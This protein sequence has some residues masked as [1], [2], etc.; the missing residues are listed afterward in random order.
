MRQVI[1]DTETTGLNPATG[2]RII[3]IGCVEMVGR[4]LTDRTSITTLILSAISMLA[5]LLFTDS[6]V[7]SYLTSQY[8]Q[9]LLRS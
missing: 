2:D 9:V 3:E 8:L 7:S 4:R 6:L 1:L 5:L